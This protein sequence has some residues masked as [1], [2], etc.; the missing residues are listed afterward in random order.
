MIIANGTARFVAVRANGY[1]PAGDPIADT[2]HE[3]EA[4]DCNIVVREK[5]NTAGESNA[6]FERVAYEILTD[7]VP[8]D[9]RFVVVTN[10]LGVAVECQIQYCEPLPS[11]DAV[12]TIAYANKR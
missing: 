4:V 12:K 7:D 3:Y 2:R 6:S 10:A 11:V 5:T 9:A 8:A 1:T